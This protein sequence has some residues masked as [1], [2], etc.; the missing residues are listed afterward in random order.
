M[1]FHQNFI[2][3]CPIQCHVIH[4]LQILLFA[5]MKRDLQKSEK[6]ERFQKI[7]NLLSE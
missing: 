5:L 6:T 1:Q 3:C 4:V 2:Q 7:P